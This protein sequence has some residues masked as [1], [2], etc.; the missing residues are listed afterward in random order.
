[1]VNLGSLFK[2][3]HPIANSNALKV[4]TR[5]FGLFVLVFA[6]IFPIA[7][8][9]ANNFES[10][11][12]ELGNKSRSKIKI[13]VQNLGD[14]GNPAALP[15]L[16]AL[17]AKQLTITEEG[18]LIILNESEDQ[19]RDVLSGEKVN[20]ESL[21]LRKSRINNVVR[22]HLSTAIAKLKLNSENSAVR[23]EAAE[24]LLKGSSSEIV[25]LVEVSFKKEKDDEVRELLSLVLAKKYLED[26]DKKA[27]LGD[28]EQDLANEYWQEQYQN[29]LNQ[30]G[31]LNYQ[32]FMQQQMNLKVSREID[33]RVKEKMK[34]EG[35][36]QILSLP[37]DKI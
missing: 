8:V 25:A 31:A 21:T 2:F 1:M 27:G 5:L 30:G 3:S 4:F 13:A 32:Q 6:C 29:Y 12:K 37:L 33:K 19:G 34:T 17:K 18:S 9:E 10:T 11:L 24:E 26:E 23:L 28:I 36:A 15:A 35:I 22:R 14:L 16:E 7:T 20:I